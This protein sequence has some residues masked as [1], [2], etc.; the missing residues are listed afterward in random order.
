MG[1]SANFMITVG[2]IQHHYSTG[3]DGMPGGHLEEILTF[4]RKEMYQST[5]T[6]AFTHWHTANGE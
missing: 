1:T 2:Q 3:M 4:F 5:P 6:E